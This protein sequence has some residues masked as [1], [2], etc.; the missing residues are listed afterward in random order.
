MKRKDT[1]K[2]YQWDLSYLYP[3]YKEWLK[4]EK[5]IPKMIS[6]LEKYR[7][8]LLDDAKTL[9]AFYKDSESLEEILERLN[10][11]AFLNIDVDLNNSDNKK[12]DDL[13]NGIIAD[14]N[15]KTSYVIPELLKSDFKTLEKYMEEEPKLKV[16]EKMFKDIFRLKEHMLSSDEE[17]MLSDFQAICQNYSKSSQYIRNKELDFGKIKLS[18]GSKV[19]LNASNLSKYARDEDRNVRKQAYELSKRAYEHNIDSLACNYIGFIKNYEVESKYRHYDSF[20]HQKLFNLDIDMSVYETLKEVLFKS[21][22]RYKRFIKLYRDVLKYDDFKVYD[23]NAPLVKGANKEYSIE[24]AKKIIL[25]TYSIY[26]D[27]Y[28]DVL[29]FAFDKK[30]IDFLP[31]EDKITG[32]YS[33][34]IPYAHP[35][36]FANYNGKILD[37]SSLCHELGHFVNQ[38]MI[39]NHQ[40][41]MYVYQ[42]SFCAE[43]AS[44]NNEFVFS[45]LYREKET[46]KDVKLELLANFIKV[47]AGNFFGA[48]RQAMFEERAHTYAKNNE[49]LSSEVLASIWLDVT[50]EVYG[51]DLKGYDPNGWASIPHYFMGGG[52]YTFNYA[53]ANIAAANLAYKILH[54][55]D[56]IKDKYQAFLKVGSSMSPIDSLKILGIDMTSVETY[57]VALKMFDEAIDEFYKLID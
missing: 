13:I 39:I 14:Y 42:S 57:E 50:K 2:K 11:Y 48:G 56:G 53:T 41:P 52:Y 1:D 3:S 35:V 10:F 27:Y 45:H 9:L 7:G 5:R 26:G 46:D 25:D 17:A 8:H 32:W 16:Y 28:T 29:K 49:P 43:V 47:F 31:S 19:K 15:V 18:D 44:L 24:D 22:D 55:E 54:N 37:V 38:Y 4:D 20:L 34:Y 6:D 23:M 33:A 12:Y 36:V 51:D 40:P 30:C 21:R